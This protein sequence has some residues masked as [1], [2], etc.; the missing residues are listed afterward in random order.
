MFTCFKSFSSIEVFNSEI[1]DVLFP[2]FFD[3]IVKLNSNVPIKI[4]AKMILLILL[5][6]GLRKFF[7]VGSFQ[8][9]A[10]LRFGE[11]A[12]VFFY[13]TKILKCN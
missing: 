8:L 10:A 3:E 13:Y 11:I 12:A 6:L 4:N 1:S 7:F 9:L 2:K 5:F